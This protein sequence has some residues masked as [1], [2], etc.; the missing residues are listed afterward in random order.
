[1]NLSGLIPFHLSFI[2]F[3]AE[4]LPRDIEGRLDIEIKNLHFLPLIIPEIGFADGAGRCHVTIGGRFPSPEL[5]GVASLKNLGFELPDSNINVK[6]TQVDLDFTNEELKIR[7]FEGRLNDGTYKISGLLKSNW[8]RVYYMDISAILRDGCTFE[9]PQ[10]YQFICR[11]ADLAMKGP[12][13]INHNVKLPRL[14]ASIYID[15]GEY[16]QHWQTLVKEWFDQDSDVQF[17]ARF[18]YPILRDLQL[19]FDVVVPNSLWVKSDLGKIKT[20]VSVNGKIVGPIQRPIF[21]G[22]V[23]LLQGDFSFFAIDHLFTIKENSYVENRNP[24][25][26]NPWYEIYAETTKPI[27]NVELTTAAGQSRSKNLKIRA[28]LSGYLNEQHRPPE[29]QAE[30]LRK[31]AGEEYQLTQR[32]IVSIL[33]L[34]E[35]DPFASETSSTNATSDLFLRHSQRYLGNR[36]ADAVGFVDEVRFDISPDALGASEFLFTKALSERFFLT[37]AF[38]FQLH[39]E[40]RIEVEYLIKKHIAVKGEK[41]ERGRFGIDLKLEQKF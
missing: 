13:V 32:Q 11:E 9:Q 19:D 7:R 10:A 17:E 4:A 24:L 14:S 18:D 15:E 6:K 33:T 8:H 21:D 40:P 27:R 23:D 29:F 3:K 30:V 39:A 20:E 22:R 34:G 38:T 2:D 5:K 36:F 1:M 41:N 35:I 12:V 28:N 31:E 16:N 37:S 26:F 25:E